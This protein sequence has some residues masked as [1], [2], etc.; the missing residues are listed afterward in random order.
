MIR[1]RR[2]TGRLIVVLGFA[3]CLMLL[4]IPRTFANH[5]GNR[6]VTVGS[7][8]DF[9]S[10]N[11][12]N[13]PAIAINPINS[14][15]VVAGANDNIDMELCNAGD[16]TTCPFTPNVGGSGFQ[17]SLNRGDTWAQPTYTGLTARHCTGAPGP[18]DPDCVAR[19]GPIAPCP[20][21]TI[22]NWPPTATRPSR[23]D[24]G[25]RTEALRGPMACGYISRT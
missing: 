9:F 4:A 10:R 15:I 1:L 11:K 5:G 2:P 3:L 19:Q 18:N 16:D 21:M 13:E 24:R 17:V 8:D 14:N 6:E 20:I 22:S 23:S 12:Q 25:R 7:N